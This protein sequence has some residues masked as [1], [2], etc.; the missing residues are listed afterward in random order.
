M[1]FLSSL[2][3]NTYVVGS[4][5]LSGIVAIYYNYLSPKPTVPSTDHQILNVPLITKDPSMSVP[6][7]TSPY[8]TKIRI[9]A[10]AQQAFEGWFLPES[11]HNGIYYP[12]GSPSYQRNNPG[13]DKGISGNGVTYFL[14]FATYDAGFTY[15]EHYIHQVCIGKHPAYPKGGLTTIEEYCHIYTDD[16]EPSPTNYANAICTALGV[17]PS[18]PLSYLLT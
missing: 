17:T 10:L 14:T 7:I 9:M 15:L 13:N 5:V 18:P 1:D 4:L 2:F 16:P 6:T 8:G 3:H 12:Q 11:T